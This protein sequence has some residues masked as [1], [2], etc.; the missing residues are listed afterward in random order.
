VDLTE[1]CDLRNGRETNEDILNGGAR[2]RGESQKNVFIGI[3]R[4]IPE[5]G[6]AIYLIFQKYL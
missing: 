3:E 6:R 4:K 1:K 5:K 2:G